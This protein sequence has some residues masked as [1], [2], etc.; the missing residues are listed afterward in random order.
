MNRYLFIL[1]LFH[2]NVS[3]I[4]NIFFI[5]QKTGNDLTIH[6]LS[7]SIKSNFKMI[8]LN[9]SIRFIICYTLKIYVQYFGNMQ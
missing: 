6:F 7:C 3:F 9:Y 4:E 1:A 5:Y 2:T 8:L